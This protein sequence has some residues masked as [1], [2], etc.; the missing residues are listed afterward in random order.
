MD[1]EDLTDSC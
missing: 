1:C